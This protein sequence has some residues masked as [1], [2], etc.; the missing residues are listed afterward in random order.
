MRRGRVGSSLAK[1][2]VGW[3]ALGGERVARSRANK[4]PKGKYSGESRVLH[5][6]VCNDM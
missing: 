5:V 6:T 3:N 2:P 4:K 1:P